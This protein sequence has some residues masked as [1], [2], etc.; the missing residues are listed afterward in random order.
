MASSSA[1]PGSGAA[2]GAG[3]SMKKLGFAANAMKRKDSFIQLFAM[4][5]ILLLSI[6]SLGQK[7]QIHRLEEDTHALREEHDSLTNRMSNIKSALHHEASKDSTGLFASRLNLLFNEQNWFVA[8]ASSPIP[9]PWVL[10]FL[11]VFVFTNSLVTFRNY[12]Y[13]FCSAS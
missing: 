8:I 2:T 4:T 5:G 6:K 12:K 1:R 3:G 13:L 10:S 11:L 9:S 7:Y